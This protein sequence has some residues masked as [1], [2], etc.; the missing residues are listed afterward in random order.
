MTRP[1]LLG[2]PG[3]VL[4]TLSLAGLASAGDWPQWRGPNRDGVAHESGL[5]RQWPADGPSLAWRATGLGKGF[6]S[7]SVAEGRVFTMGDSA[8]AGHVLAL[9]ERDGKVLWTSA[10]IGKPGGGPAGTRCTPSVD[11]GLVYALGQWGE[12]VCVDAASGQERWR[13]SVTKEFGGGVPGWQYSESP[14]VDGNKV[15]CTPGGRKGAVVAF[16]KATGEVVWQSADFTD[17]A[18]YSS[19]IAAM[20]GG[21]RQYIQ[22]TPAS[23]VGLAA[24]DGKVLWRA[25]RPGKT[26]VVPTPIFHDNHVFVTSGYGVGCNLFKVTATGGNFE[27]GQVYANT[28]LANHHGGVLRVGDCLY[29]HSDSRGWVCMELKTGKIL[30]SHRGVG[31]GAVTCAD[32]HLYLRSEDKSR[33]TIALV[34]ATPDGYREKGRFNPPD[35]SGKETWPHPVVANGRLYIRDQDVLLCYDVKA[36]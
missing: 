20:I 19:I 2:G 5:L 16:N 28:D 6:S 32:G 30:W 31:K 3:A 12:L 23:V 9:A 34:E 25:N 35:L 11:G 29:G 21:R 27:A 24:E 18:H 22:L 17:S 7:V 4:L 14:L 26:A 8:A 33:G 15:L 10:P 13:H 36:K 1:S